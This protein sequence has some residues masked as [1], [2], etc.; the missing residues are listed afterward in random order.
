MTNDTLKMQVT[1]LRDEISKFE[2]ARAVLAMQI[3][4]ADGENLVRLNQEVSLVNAKLV[5]LQQELSDL[6]NA[7][8]DQQ[9]NEEH[10]AWSEQPEKMLHKKAMAE[11]LDDEDF[12]AAFNQQVAKER[13]AIRKQKLKRAAITGCAVVGTAAIAVVTGHAVVLGVYALTKRGLA[14]HI[15]GLTA[16]GITGAALGHQ[17]LK[18][19]HAHSEFT[20]PE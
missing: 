10:D 17:T 3:N 12:Q 20:N 8:M 4:Y 9:A 15:A 5:R 19:A 14:A 16:A 6:L 2:E 18:H 1:E 7:E 11:A 13:K